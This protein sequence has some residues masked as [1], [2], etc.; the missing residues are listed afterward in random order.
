LEGGKGKGAKEKGELCQTA[1]SVVSNSSSRFNGLFNMYSSVLFSFKQNY[2]HEVGLW[3]STKATNKATEGERE[4]NSPVR[5][6][7]C[8]FT[9]HD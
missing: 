1:K 4:K 9:A 6:R 7:G 2:M 5:R 3:Y 8:C